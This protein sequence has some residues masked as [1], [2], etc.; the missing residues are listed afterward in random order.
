MDP[1]TFI[2]LLFKISMISPQ[3]NSYIDERLI[4]QKS[5]TEI[6]ELYR[7]NMVNQNKINDY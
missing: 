5:R 1:I 7:S 6:I 3:K 2:S 4:N